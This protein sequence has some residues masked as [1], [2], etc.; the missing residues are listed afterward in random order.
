M[1][2]EAQNLSGSY[3]YF[4]NHNFSYLFSYQNPHF[5][6][7]WFGGDS[8]PH[9]RVGRFPPPFGFCFPFSHFSFFFSFLFY[10]YTWGCILLLWSLRW[11]S[12]IETCDQIAKVFLIFSSSS[13]FCFLFSFSL[14]FFAPSC[15]IYL[16]LH[17][18][19]L[20]SSMEIR[21]WE[22]VTKLLRCCCSIFL[23]LEA[24]QISN[25]PWF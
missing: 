5:L 6:F 25:L 17:P 21:N 8:D 9:Q 1:G 7:L 18:L 4:L 24:C 23:S 11:T 14:F 15:F 2:C 3:L 16:R 19:S 13:G 12:G 10:I 20:V 22:F